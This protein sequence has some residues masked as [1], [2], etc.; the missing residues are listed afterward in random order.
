MYK[1]NCLIEMVL[2][3]SDA[4]TA[5][6]IFENRAALLTHLKDTEPHSLIWYPSNTSV[7]SGS[8]SQFD[9]NND[10]DDKTRGM[11]TKPAK[12][13]RQVSN[14]ELFNTVGTG[15]NLPLQQSQSRMAPT[16]TGRRSKSVLSPEISN[17]QLD[18]LTNAALQS[19]DSKN[20]YHDIHPIIKSVFDS[21]H[22]KDSHMVMGL[23]AAGSAQSHPHENFV[24][25][26]RAYRDLIQEKP[27]VGDPA[28][29][30]NYLRAAHGV[31]LSGPKVNPYGANIAGDHTKITSD[32][33]MRYSVL[34]DYNPEIETV[35]PQQ[36]AAIH[37]G[38]SHV[39]KR[40]GWSNAQTQAAI[41]AHHIRKVTNNHPSFHQSNS[42]FRH[43]SKLY[44]GW[45]NPTE[46]ENPIQDYGQ[47]LYHNFDALKKVKDS[48]DAVRLKHPEHSKAAGSN[49]SFFFNSESPSGL[50]KSGGALDDTHVASAFPSKSDS[51]KKLHN[52]IDVKGRDATTTSQFG[53][54][55]EPGPG[56][57][58]KTLTRADFLRGH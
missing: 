44:G 35:S 34:N 40:L 45:L 55:D 26:M 24:K 2:G 8:A 13:T 54:P 3:G 17:D 9:Y 15:A 4:S 23:L 32:R 7:K 50:A 33:H 27:L 11:F 30:S 14:R 21:E 57:S 28:S 37:Q 22:Y 49:K 46:T 25:S 1:V 18:Y 29:T 5:C 43:Y 31:G 16:P 36:F 38:V 48:M 6:S 47:Y 56:G 53:W 41:W 10:L 12:F 58:R 19:R 52:L 51:S 20:W 42:A 39:A